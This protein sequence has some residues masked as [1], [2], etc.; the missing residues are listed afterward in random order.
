MLGSA[1]R[2]VSPYL[3]YVESEQKRM[4]GMAET[5]ED[6]NNRQPQPLTAW[7]LSLLKQTIGLH[8]DI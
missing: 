1:I 2:S 6:G 3:R 5:T 8:F 4:N 7:L